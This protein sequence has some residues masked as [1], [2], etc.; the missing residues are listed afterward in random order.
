MSMKKNG[1]IE[2][3]MRYHKIVLLIISLLVLLGIY[4]LVNMPK[5]EFPPFTIRQGVI[6]GVYPGATSSQVEEQLAKPLEQFL[7]TYKE[8]KKNKTYS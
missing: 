4:A 2:S 6:V 3:A 8:V 1:F 5:Q 7:F